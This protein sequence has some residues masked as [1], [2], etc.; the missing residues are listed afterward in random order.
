MRRDPCALVAEQVLPV[1]EQH[2]CR[3]KLPS[4]GVVKVV[5]AHGPEPVLRRLTPR[6][7]PGSVPVTA[8]S[9]PTV[10]PKCP[11]TLRNRVRHAVGRVFGSIPQGAVMDRCMQKLSDEGYEPGKKLLCLKG[12]ELGFGVP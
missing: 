12:A 4:I 9:S 1:L 2:P 7:I 3:P 10:C 8:D 11:E 6:R 5:H